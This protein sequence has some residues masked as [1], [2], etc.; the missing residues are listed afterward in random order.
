[1]RWVMACL[2]PSGACFVA[3][4]YSTVT[5][6][7]NLQQ[8][9]HC[10]KS[11]FKFKETPGA[12]IASIST[13][14]GVES[15]TTIVS[16]A[17]TKASTSTGNFT[18]SCINRLTQLLLVHVHNFSAASSCI[19]RTISTTWQ[20]TITGQQSLSAQPALPGASS[21]Q[22]PKPLADSVQSLAG[23]PPLCQES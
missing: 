1:M 20:N 10:F 5:C 14:E 17:D 4:C 22:P 7:L 16:E 11:L 12:A 21:G 3:A 15:I 9:H 19:H 6:M 13:D 2:F 8:I 18:V 23:K